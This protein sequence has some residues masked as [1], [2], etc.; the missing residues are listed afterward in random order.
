MP[1]MRW[2]MALW[3]IGCATQSAPIEG[4][5]TTGAA[6]ATLEVF[7]IDQAGSPIEGASVDG[8]RTDGSGRV[9]IAGTDD[10]SVEAEGFRS[11]RWLGFDA[12]SI[13][14]PLRALAA[15]PTA[16]LEVSVQTDA[17]RVHVGVA[18]PL[19]V[20]EAVTPVA[21]DGGCTLE[22]PAGE[23][24]VYAQLEDGTSG[25][26]APLGF[27]LAEP[28]TLA[29]GETRA[30][31]LAPFDALRQVTVVVPDTPP[32]LDAVVGVPGVSA[33]G[34]LLLFASGGDRFLVPDLD[35]ATLWALATASS[36]AARSRSVVR[37]G[38]T[39]ARL[40]P[41]SLRAPPD[42]LPDGALSDVEGADLVSVEAAGARIL[43]FDGR[44]QIV[45][46][47]GD[48]TVTA[49]EAPRGEH[50]WRLRDVEEKWT[51]R[52]SRRVRL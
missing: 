14:V 21:C 20:D 12:A 43:V 28:L 23:A 10:V 51:R 35:G 4:G 52:A 6:G 2:M 38:A 34:R 50:G 5:G 29:P 42:L 25:V 15:Q 33:D 13:T 26:P 48:V 11:E 22:V 27:A 18:G 39:P 16:S 46:P 37:S 40:E 44:R 7:V 47:T 3:L 17:S 31:T 45:P 36:D 19:A 41:P 32:G 30:V 8:E 9:E 1:A 24:L 49:I